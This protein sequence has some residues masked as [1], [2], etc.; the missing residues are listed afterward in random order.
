MYRP[1]ESSPRVPLEIVD[2]WL[3]RATEALLSTWDD[4]AG[5]FWRDSWETRSDT[6]DDQDD[7]W[8]PALGRGKGSTSNNR[9][10]QALASASY[11]FTENDLAAGSSLPS[12]VNR[13]LRRM[14][15]EYF[16]RDLED[17]RYHG[18][19]RE[20]PFTDAQLLLSLCLAIS[21]TIH[22][23]A[24]VEL[25]R[26]D[27]NRLTS[28]LRKLSTLVV[29]QLSG[30]GVSVHEAAQ[31][32]HFLTLFTV[33]AL[34]SAK[35]TLDAMSHKTASIDLEQ[36]PSHP[37]LTSRVRDEIVRQLGLHLLPAPG[38][39][40]SAL[41]SSC[42]L[43]GRFSGDA[44]SPLLQQAVNALVEDQSDRGMWTTSGVLSFGRR[45]LVYIPSIE[46]SLALANFTL[47]D[48]SEGDMDIFNFSLPALDASFRFVQSSYL[49]HE[50]KAGWRNDRNQSG[51]EVESWTTGVV[52]QF[53]IAY[54][55]VLARARQEEILRK[56]RASR[57]PTMFSN[58]WTDLEAIIPSP[59]KASILRSATLPAGRLARF[60][61]LVDPTPSNSIVEGVLNEILLP[62]LTSLNERPDE[63]ASFLLY[64]PPGSRKTSFVEKMAA[65]LKW[66]LITLSPPVFLRS[67]IEG[68]EAAADEIFEDLFHLRRVVVLF[69]EC[70]E[71]FRWRPTPISI[72]SRTVGAFITS[73]MLPRLQRLR[74][75]RWI[76]FVINT[77]VE[78][79]EL[80]DSV[81]RRGRL[82]K[83]AR[84][85]HPVLAAQL[86]YL[87]NWR[88]RESGRSLDRRQLRWFEVHL[89]KVEAA[90]A[91]HRQRLE[92]ERKQVQIEYPDRGTEFR[93]RMIELQHE[94]ARLLTKVVT[95]TSLD[96]LAERCLDEGRQPR[97]ASSSQLLKNLEEEFQRFGPDSFAPSQAWRTSVRPATG[98]GRE[99]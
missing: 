84:V 33:R 20:N 16:T 74:D 7:S 12:R 61:G 42:A 43:M 69:D 22:S 47:R 44:D 66:P 26:D 72:E 62:T 98:S 83:V 18:E 8:A 15:C 88:S 57:E 28:H 68:F 81:T 29:A 6:A 34:D 54:R 95:F 13:A 58:Y 31:P 89:T 48:L 17:L 9:S 87:K 92:E 45:R 59:E 80:D 79:F 63:T 93:D 36:K 55:E 14:A 90:M 30:D 77:N 76:V 49:R 67:G 27:A 10:F 23:A 78:A 96:T 41:I 4:E 21:P 39:D 97:I 2:R 35:R 65:D 40:S 56:Y 75:A 94:S 50:N 19:N 24:K 64:G 73:G 46:L 91:P 3:I 51:L 85:G 70:E 86:R 52:L 1:P 32:H 71:F 11:F 53:L 60:E 82:D 38:F 99:P 37:T 5:N 25:S